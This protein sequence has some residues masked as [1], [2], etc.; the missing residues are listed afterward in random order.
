MNDIQFNDLVS[1]Y[2]VNQPK[3]VEGLKNTSFFYY[4]NKLWLM[5]QSL[6]IYE[7]MPETIDID[8]INDWLYKIGYLA[9]FEY[10]N[11]IY[12]LNCGFDGYNIYYKP[13]SI[14][15]SNPVLGQH[16]YKIGDK[17]ELLYLS[18]NNAQYINLRT[19]VTRYAELL[20]QCDATLNTTLMNSRVTSVFQ[21][22]NDAD[23]KSL[24]KMYDDATKGKPAIFLKK[25]AK[26]LLDDNKI[27]IF[28]AKNTFI[29]KDIT[30]TKRVI[31]NEFL[32]EIGINNAN[33][34]KR[35]RLN[36]D[37][38][39]ANNN[40]TFINISKWKNT[41]ESCLNKANEVFNLDMKV[42]YNLEVINQL[43][44]NYN[45]NGGDGNDSNIN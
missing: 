41:I 22:D 25:G 4:S 32:T 33:A 40:E 26:N 44:E 42:H 15:I 37:E 28:N 45:I 20:A 21:A 36:T 2:M 19:L 23:V 17:A 43:Q 6:F 31:I 13:T 27:N 16:T 29:G 14:T 30:D 1:N 11:N 34:S 9:I 7:N 18:R 35:E 39:N 38:V 5:I 3:D 12:C 24:Q 8:F 10:N